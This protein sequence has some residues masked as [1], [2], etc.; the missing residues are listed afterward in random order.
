MQSYVNQISD[1]RFIDPISTLCFSLLTVGRRPHVT[2]FGNDYDTPDGTGI[3]DYLHV[4]GLANGH[5]AALR[6]IAGNNGK[7]GNEKLNV[8]N[9]ALER[10]TLSLI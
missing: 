4:M 9:L 6:Y 5:V 1:D 7:S 10:A 8:F 3:R 2:I